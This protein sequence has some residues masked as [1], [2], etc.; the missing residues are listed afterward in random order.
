MSVSKR[1][2]QKTAVGI[3]DFIENPVAEK[4]VN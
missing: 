2:I 3:S 4:I 1:V